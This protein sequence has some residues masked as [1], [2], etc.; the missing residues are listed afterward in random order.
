MKNSR[1]IIISL[2]VGIFQS[3][4]AMDWLNNFNNVVCAGNMSVGGVSISQ[5]NGMVHYNGK[6]YRGNSISII[7]DVAYIDG[8]C[9]NDLEKKRSITQQKIV[10]SGTVAEKLR[11]TVPF[12]I[13]CCFPV[14]SQC[15]I[16]ANADSHGFL[17]LSGD[18]NLLEC[19][20]TKVINDTLYIQPKD[21]VDLEFTSPLM[22]VLFIDPRKELTLVGAAQ[23]YAFTPMEVESFSLCQQGTTRVVELPLMAQF[24][25]LDLGGSTYALIKGTVKNTEIDLGGCSKCK[26]LGLIS[27]NLKTK[28]SGSSKLEAKVR[29]QLDCNLSGASAISANII[30]GISSDVDLSGSSK[31]YL[32]G[33]CK[34]LKVG[35]SGASSCD[36]GA[37]A[38]V[39]ARVKSSGASCVRVKAQELQKTKSGAASIKNVH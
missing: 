31:A 5:S 1:I 8:K 6:S 4:H 38:V 16:E 10:G 3:S 26:A 11:T 20:E 15:L 23:T 28:I 19:I 24:F 39:S 7:N 18:D 25:N 30:E 29:H 32:E 2:F 14:I 37:L 22:A 36:G 21:D 17:K 33:I 27:D 13:I 12:S 34:K 9:V 35:T